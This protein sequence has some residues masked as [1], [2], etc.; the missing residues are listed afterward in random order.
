MTEYQFTLLQKKII[1]KENIDDVAS[2]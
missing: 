2:I 1:K